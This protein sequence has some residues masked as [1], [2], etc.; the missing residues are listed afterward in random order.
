VQNSITGVGDLTAEQRDAL[1]RAIQA[2]AS[3]PLTVAIM[4]QTGVGKSSLLNALFGAQLL[5]GDVRPTTK[6]PE[7]VTV[8]GSSGHPII[9][10][11]M[12][13]IGESESADRAY[14]SMYSQKL[15]ECD[16][17]LWAIHA[18][19]R[20]TVF[21]AA[22]LRSLLAG[23]PESERRTVAAKLTFV[24]TKADLL[25]PPP[26][27]Y[28]RDGGTGSFEPSKKI[29]QRLDEKAS[30]YQEQLL[31]PHGSLNSA[32]TFNNVGFD[33]S[34]P[35]FSYDEYRVRYEGFMSEEFCA[36]YSQQ[37]PRFAEVFERLCENHRVIPCSAQYRYNLVRLMVCIVNKLGEG[38]IARFKRF[39]DDPEALNTVP[40]SVMRKY[41]NLVVWDKRK[42][43]VTF[44]LDD[45]LS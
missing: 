12:P 25:V 36:R 18:D 4:G 24:L 30:Y 11:D 7:A 3:K 28:V 35:R 17:V 19:S 31:L 13:G 45:V 33:L 37:Y 20:S 21:D 42:G 14:M 32:E 6:E 22:A 40:V 41:G 43:R 38:A 16:V 5:V 2:E 26:W 8:K 34:D 10:W 15:I 23:L 9:F 44:D 27:I 1:G 39:V 29:Q